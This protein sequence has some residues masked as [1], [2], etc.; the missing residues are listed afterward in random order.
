MHDRAS[1]DGV[2]MIEDMHSSHWPDY[3]GSRRGPGTFIECAEA[4]I[5]GLNGKHVVEE[6]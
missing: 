6:F 4:K 5:D 3:G 2:Y 1:P